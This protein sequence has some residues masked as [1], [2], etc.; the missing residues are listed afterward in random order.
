MPALRPSLIAAALMAGGSLAH[1]QTAN[2]MA[3]NVTSPK[4]A[5]QASDASA[6]AGDIVVVCTGGYPN[7]TTSQPAPTINWTVTMPA[8]L[9]S[10]IVSTSGGNVSDILLFID[11]QGSVPPGVS[12]PPGFGANAPPAVCPYS[13]ASTTGC[14]AYPNLLDGI[15]VMTS[16]PNPLGSPVAA[17]PAANI[18][19]GVVNGNSV[20]FFGVPV[21]PPGSNGA[22][23]YRITNLRVNAASAPAGS[24]TSSV[25]V[26]GAGAAL[27]SLNA[28]TPV[29]AASQSGNSVSGAGYQFPAPVK[30]APGEIINF[31]VQGVGGTLTGPVTASGFPLPTTLAGIS[32]SVTPAGTNGTSPSY[33]V[34]LLA[35]RPM[36]TCLSPSASPCG[37]YVALTAQIPFEI[38]TVPPGFVAAPLSLVVAENGVPGSVF[39]LNPVPDQIHGANACDVEAGGG[40]CDPKGAIVTHANGAPVSETTPAKPGE[41]LVMYAF[42]LGATTPP[43]PTGQQ[44]TVPAPVTQPVQLNFDYR[45]NAAPSRSLSLPPVCSTAPACPSTQPLFAGLTPGFAGLYQINFV[46]PAPPPGTPACDATYPPDVS[47]PPLGIASNL[48]VS[49]IGA[50]SF[51]GANLCVD[52]GGK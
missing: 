23:T 29:V 31:F 28:N 3:C 6:P 25:T 39:E 41:E 22:R 19:Q 4:T 46:V 44:P 38:P 35:V 14:P 26:R 48:T 43:V 24:V 8:P 49:V 33:A 47:R 12:S 17:P 36:R 34:P 11:D 13:A 9:T 2:V 1:A 32:A 52:T 42:G 51:D 16:A 21:L 7:T 10:P 50:N 40:P 15:P 45:P 20:R 5:I 27:L 37:A 18:Y 30:V